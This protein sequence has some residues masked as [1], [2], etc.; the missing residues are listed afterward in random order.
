MAKLSDDAVDGLGMMSEA[1]LKALKGKSV[2][3][4]EN[5][6][7]ARRSMQIP[8]RSKQEYEDLAKDPAHNGAISENTIR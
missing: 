1:E 5:I 7:K 2:G 6:I 3:E 4:I 8:N